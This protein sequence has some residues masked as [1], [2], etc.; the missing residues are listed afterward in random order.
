MQGGRGSWVQFLVPK[1]GEGEG[2]FC[3][4]CTLKVQS[5]HCVCWRGPQPKH[6]KYRTQSDIENP[7]N[8]PAQKCISSPYM[9]SLNPNTTAPS[10]LF[11]RALLRLRCGYR[12]TPNM[13]LRL[14]PAQ[15][16]RTNAQ[17]HSD[18]ATISQARH[19]NLLSAAHATVDPGRISQPRERR[20]R[21]Y[22]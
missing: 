16:F 3:L 22:Q 19:N 15:T 9:T 20:M 10:A 2:V 14:N 4:H 1:F 17:P 13:W 8:R 7:P 18:R 6:E 12:T 21:R 11:H 5:Y